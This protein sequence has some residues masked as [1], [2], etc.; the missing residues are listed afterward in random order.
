MV[1]FSRSVNVSLKSQRRSSSCEKHVQ[2]MCHKLTWP[3]LVK[4]FVIVALCEVGL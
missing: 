2:G 3:R 1:S 4:V